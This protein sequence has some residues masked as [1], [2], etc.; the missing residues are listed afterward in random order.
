MACDEAVYLAIALIIFEGFV[1][2]DGR[3]LQYNELDM[4]IWWLKGKIFLIFHVLAM[5]STA[6]YVKGLH[7][8]SLFEYPLVRALLPYLYLSDSFGA[9]VLG[10]GLYYGNIWILSLGLLILTN[11]FLV[12]IMHGIFAV[13]KPSDLVSIR[14][15]NIFFFVQ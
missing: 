2:S 5:L 10:Y 1:R 11:L 13:H 3:F 14:G 8:M 9:L 4:E 7:I 6:L 12:H 15:L